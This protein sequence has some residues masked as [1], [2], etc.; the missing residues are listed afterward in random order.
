M[1]LKQLWFLLMIQFPKRLFYSFY[2]CF[3]PFF[4]IF[5]I[6]YFISDFIPNDHESFSQSNSQNIPKPICKTF[7]N[8]LLIFLKKSNKI[9]N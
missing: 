1:N 6:L 2:F 7:N 5:S 9:Y 4:E 3:I 8:I